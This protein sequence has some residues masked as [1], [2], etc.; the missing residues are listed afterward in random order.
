MF[1]DGPLYGILKVF[2]KN[3]QDLGC[4]MD[5]VRM[6]SW[7]GKWEELFSSRSWGKYP[8]EIIVSEISRRFARE[9]D[10]RQIK[11]ADIGCGPGASTWFLAREGF[12]VYSIDGSPSAIQQCK[13]RLSEASLEAT[14]LRVGDFCQAL[15]WADGTFDAVIDVAALYAN[16]LESSAN[17]L[18]EILRVLKP[19]GFFLSICFSTATWGYGKGPKGITPHSFLNIE[20]GPL[21]EKGY[22]QFFDDEL[23]RSHYG[24]FAELE[25]ERSSRTYLCGT[26]VVENFIVKG[27]KE[28][29]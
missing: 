11:I 4:A 25:I 26:K 28:G 6:K 2:P 1:F 14:D 22:V 17:A 29:T 19:K 18:K 24:C 27:L 13:L 9:R 7:D 15:P 20:E 21:G 5:Q 12:S 8:S 23:L 3:Y 16:P 10:P